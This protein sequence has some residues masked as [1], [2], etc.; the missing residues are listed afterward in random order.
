MFENGFGTDSTSVTGML[1][2]LGFSATWGVYVVFVR[3]NLSVYPVHLAYGLVSLLTCVP[4]VALMFRFGHWH[5]LLHLP[6]LQWLWLILSALIGLTLGHVFYYRAIRVMGPIASE[7]CMLLIPFQ[8]AI[9]AHFLMGDHLS[10]TQWTA[11]GILIL[12]CTLLLRAR[13]TSGR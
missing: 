4:L 3:R 7:G 1:M 11:G 13:F 9:L 10:G 8:T 2:L 5:V 12:G 6:L